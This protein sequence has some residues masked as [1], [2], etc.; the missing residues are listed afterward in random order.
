[1]CRTSAEM[2]FTLMSFMLWTM[3]V[4]SPGRSFVL[5]MTSVYAP[6]GSS[7]TSIEVLTPPL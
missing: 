7:L 4:S 2:T 6:S 5:M 3:S 1:M